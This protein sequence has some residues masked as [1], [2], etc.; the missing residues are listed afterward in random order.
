MSS[1][2]TAVSVIIPIYNNALFLK[3]TLQ[4]VR[5][6][7]FDCFEVIAVNDGSSDD[8]ERI[9]DQFV[10]LD[11]RFIKINQ[12]NQGVSV[13]RNA[14]LAVAK[15]KYVT[16]IDGDDTIPENAFQEMYN[17]ANNYQSDLI[18]GGIQRIDGSVKKVNQRTKR[19]KDKRI[20]ERDDL[21]LVHGLSMCNKWFLK[22]I[23]D[24]YQIQ[25]ESYRHLEDGV[26]LYNF[27]QYVS[28]INY[29]DAIIYNYIKRVPTQKASVTQ[30]VSEGLLESAIHAYE[31]IVELTK[32]Y[33]DEFKQELAYRVNSTTFVG[34]YYKKIWN[35]S[36]KDE[37]LLLDQMK[38]MWQKQS[39]EYRA[40]TISMHKGLELEKGFR[41]KEQLLNDI[42]FRIVITPSVSQDK[43]NLILRSLYGQSVPSFSVIIDERYSKK[44]DKSFKKMKN[45]S[46]DKMDN[47]ELWAQSFLQNE[48]VKYVLFMD[49]DVTFD[50]DTMAK[51]YEL[52]QNTKCPVLKMDIAEFKEKK[53]L[54]KYIFSVERM[55]SNKFS[56]AEVVDTQ[57]YIVQKE[58]MLECIKEETNAK[59]N[60]NDTVIQLTKKMIRKFLSPLRKTKKQSVNVKKGAAVLD[61][62]FDYPID[63]QVVLLEGIGKHIKGNILYI[64]KEL[65]KE[66]YGDLNIFVSVTENSKAAV[67]KMLQKQNLKNVDTVIVGSKKYKELLSTSK[68]LVNE[69]Y[70]PNYWIKKPEQRYINIW[71]GTPLKKLGAGKTGGRIHGDG[72][73]QKNFISAEYLLFPNEFTEEKLL[74]DC[75]VDELVL[76]KSLMLGYPR[77]GRLLEDNPENVQI[78]RKLAGEDKYLVAYMPTYRDVD[79]DNEQIVAIRESLDYLE[80]N[81]PDDYLVYVNLHHK[82]AGQIDYVRY[83]KIKEF[84]NEYDTYQVLAVMDCLC[85]D[86][87]SLMFDFAATRKKVV[88]YCYD[89]E[90][91]LADRGLYIDLE[92]LPFDKARTKQELLEVIQMGKNYDDTD[93]IND[94]CSFDSDKNAEKLCELLINDNE[95]SVSVHIK[96]TNPL[97]PVLIYSDGWHKCEATDKM[98]EMAEREELTKL[99]YLSYKEAFVNNYLDSA[100]PLLNKFRSIGIKA[101]QLFTDEQ[102]KIRKQYQAGKIEFKEMMDSLEVAYKTEK[103]RCYDQLSFEKVFLY[104]TVDADKI[105]GFSYFDCEKYLCMQ[106]DL[107]EFIKRNNR[108]L[109]DAISWF[110]YKGGIILVK[111]QETKDY[112]I[113]KFTTESVKIGFFYE[114]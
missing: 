29:C 72:P 110:V 1:Q 6:Q 64:L 17:V 79:D 96:N 35:L 54:T 70:F 30:S 80:N 81:M 98:Y 61:Y 10:E 5:N 7:T 11:K 65:T 9:I 114:C 101:E 14:G 2:K 40:K 36:E 104:D 46:F 67:T 100:Y 58:A 63:N 93:F 32:G 38:G 76:G 82:M 16:F 106:D 43:V 68:Y 77:T 111:E 22:E 94:F 113:D 3:Q 37:K 89:M 108:Y 27:M 109:I 83:E 18:I 92:E 73:A 8:S 42:V 84:P 91:Y 59:D 103:L 4:S 62:Y 86:Y 31:R 52:L 90:K 13:A 97:N 55:N 60:K 75:Y 26:F 23:I 85:T 57:E 15:G 49:E 12:K 50:Y 41:T 95:D 45:L 44:V 74:K 19:L 112:M 69:V 53:C 102:K 87:S 56:L 28:R 34:D 20:I 39:E 105:I 25:V 88:L 51:A 78:K 24:K 107:L 71:H 33:S 66:K 99:I 48:D 21:D 47:N